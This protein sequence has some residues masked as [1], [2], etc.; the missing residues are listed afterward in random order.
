MHL[1]LGEAEFWQQYGSA[2]ECVIAT[3]VLQGGKAGDRRPAPW[4]FAHAGNA[5]GGR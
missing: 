4:A 5:R 2:N 3:A 1:G